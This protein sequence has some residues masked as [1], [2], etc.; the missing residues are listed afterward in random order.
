M[1]ILVL[2]ASQEPYENDGMKPFEA[3]WIINEHEQKQAKT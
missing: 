2:T 3:F 1:S